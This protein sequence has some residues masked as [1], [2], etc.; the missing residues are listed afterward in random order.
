[1]KFLFALEEEIISFMTMKEKDIPELND[2]AFISS[3]EFVTDFCDHLKPAK[4]KAQGSNASYH[5]DVRLS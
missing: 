1:M 4:H 5:G 2:F 3:T